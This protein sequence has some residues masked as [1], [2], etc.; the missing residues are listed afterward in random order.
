MNRHEE[1]MKRINTKR[2]SLKTD[3]LCPQTFISS[4]RYYHVLLVSNQITPNVIKNQKS[5]IWQFNEHVH[6]SFFYQKTKNKAQPLNLIN[7]Y[8]R[9]CMSEMFYHVNGEMI[10]SCVI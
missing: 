4:F 3:T 2:E 8:Q 7:L 9:I 1:A 5:E 10:T 6:L